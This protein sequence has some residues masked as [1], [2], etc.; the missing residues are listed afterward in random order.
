MAF[1]AIGVRASGLK[2]L[3]A[4]KFTLCLEDWE[5]EKSHAH[6]SLNIGPLA[7]DRLNCWL[8]IEL[9]DHARLVKKQQQQTIYV[10]N[11]SF[12]KTQPRG[13]VRIMYSPIPVSP[14]V[15]GLEFNSLSSICVWWTNNF[16]LNAYD[17]TKLVGPNV[18][19]NWT[20]IND[21]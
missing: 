9:C 4:N 12:K 7:S 20:F 19:L 13:P 3:W 8:G 5:L 16:L 14:R 1:L 11:P 17:Q 21:Q 15:Q 18:F 6:F 2:G 10:S